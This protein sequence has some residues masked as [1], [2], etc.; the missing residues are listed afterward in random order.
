MSKITVTVPASTANLGPGFDSLALALDL[1]NHTHLETTNQGLN[2]VIEGEGADQLPRDSSN[3]FVRAFHAIFEIS[4]QPL[5]GLIIN[6]MNLIPPA[7]GL[8]SSS[9]AI[10]AGTLA[11]DALLGCNLSSSQILQHVLEFEDH[12]DNAAAAL[13]GGLT[14]VA[15]QE[16]EIFTHQVSIPDLRIVVILPE[17]DLST[18]KMRQVLPVQVALQDAVFNLSRLSLTIQALQDGNYE[19]MRWSMKDRL[20]QPYRTPLI[21]AFQEVEKAA[22]EAGAAAVTLSG[23]GPALV[24]FAPQHHEVIADAMLA[25]FLAAGIKA[26]T[27]VLPVNQSGAIVT[28][29]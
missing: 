6:Q 19:M 17:L 3:L 21:P 29:E 27:F 4:A 11:A 15:Q 1:C 22:Y 26:R 16:G 28:M 14:I 8:G 20:H 10:L 7:S 2:M 5:P 23:A 13:L 24:A 9:A 25:A 18:S 12:L